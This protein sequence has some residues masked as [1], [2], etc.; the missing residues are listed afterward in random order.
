MKSIIVLLALIVVSFSLSPVFAA[1]PS[2]EKNWT[3]YGKTGWFSWKEQV[4]GKKFISDEGMMYAFGATRTDGVYKA[5]SLTETLE[6]SIGHPVYDGQK[7]F[8]GEPI[9]R[10]NGYIG[11]REEVRADVK[12][13]ITDD[14]AV[15]PFVGLGHKM[16]FRAMEG[17]LWNTLYAPVG[18]RV[19]HQITK[20]V[21]AFVETGITLP[22]FTA[23]YM[24]AANQGRG[25]EDVL[26]I[27]KAKI[28]QFAEIGVNIS[29]FSLSLSYEATKFSKSDAVAS[30]SLDSKW[31]AHFYQPDSATSTTWL[32][33]GYNF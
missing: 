21:S 1:E 14:L 7:L 11:T 16:W 32:K 4:D 33:I 29:S 27:P 24:F 20:T 18:A 22:I 13:P 10:V 25:Y 5:L 30:K 12:I 17:K 3:I 26:T 15:S 31:V 2:A 28:G 19:G 23:D 8:T 9:H 6:L